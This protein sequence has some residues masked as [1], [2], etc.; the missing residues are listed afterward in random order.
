MLLKLL[1]IE[2]LKAR[3]SLALLLMFAIALVV[4]ALN[5]L[6]LVR[7]HELGAISPR[8]W[9]RLWH[10]TTVLWCSFV[11]PLYIALVA[12]LLN[13]QEHRHHGWRLML[14]LPISQWQLFAVKT[15]LAW[16]FVLASTLVLW[17]GTALAALALGAAGASV[18]GAFAYAVL[19]AFGKLALACLPMVVLQHALSWRLRSLVAPL[20]LGVITTSGIVQVGSSSYWVWYPWSYATM[21]LTGSEA[22][23]QQQALLLAGAVALGLFAVSAAWLARRE[24]AN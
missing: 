10:G 1:R 21:A 7:Q 13:G 8:D 4:V 5:V 11:M 15:V 22:A 3:R 9:L 18:E 16:L 20:A 14:T 24:V 19:P 23:R 2:L 12:G 6:M 17:G